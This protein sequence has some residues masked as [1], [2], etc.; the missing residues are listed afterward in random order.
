MKK[1]SKQ[2]MKQLQGGTYGCT[3]SGGTGQWIY[4]SGTRPSDSTISGDISSYCSSG[5]A[6]CGYNQPQQ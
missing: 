6:T 5:A 3:C 4:T 2:E 1:L